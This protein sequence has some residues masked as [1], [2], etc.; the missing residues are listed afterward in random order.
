V[1]VEELLFYRFVEPRII[2]RRVFERDL[3]GRKRFGAARLDIGPAG[4]LKRR[5]ARVLAFR[6]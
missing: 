6:E 1:H 5:L 3:P 2:A 4:Q